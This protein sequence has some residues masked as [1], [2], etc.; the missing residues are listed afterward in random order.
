MAWSG[1][2]K[3]LVLTPRAKREGKAGEREGEKRMQ[4]PRPVCRLTTLTPAP[5]AEAGGLIYEWPLKTILVKRARSQESSR[6]PTQNWCY[7]RY[8]SWYPSHP[9]ASEVMI[10]SGLPWVIISPV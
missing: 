3:A 9:P 8:I 5:E 10:L 1:M 2:C 7:L 6:A 4:L